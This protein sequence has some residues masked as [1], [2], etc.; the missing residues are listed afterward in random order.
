VA[1]RRAAAKQTAASERQNAAAWRVTGK[2]G[3]AGSWQT[4]TS[5]RSAATETA[6]RNDKQVKRLLAAA[7]NGRRRGVARRARNLIKSIGYFGVAS[8]T[9]YKICEASPWRRGGEHCVVQTE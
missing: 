6:A 9:A 4:V 2:R 3:S 8:A 5:K 1:G 7:A